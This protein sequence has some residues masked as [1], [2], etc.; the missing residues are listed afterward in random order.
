MAKHTLKIL[1]LNTA[2]FLKYVWPFYGIIHE[3]VNHRKVSRKIV[4]LGPQLCFL[5]AFHIFFSNNHFLFY[6]PTSSDRL[7][8]GYLDPYTSTKVTLDM[9]K[10]V[11]DKISIYVKIYCDLFQCISQIMMWHVNIIWKIFSEGIKMNRSACLTLI[12][13]INFLNI[14]MKISVFWNTRDVKDF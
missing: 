9:I 14:C 13:N 7:T 11:Y 10:L 6:S 2:R 1:W 3:R 8:H 5:K 12:Q 4:N